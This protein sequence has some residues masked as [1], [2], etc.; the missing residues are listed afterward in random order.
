MTRTSLI[1]LL[2][3]GLISSVATT[4]AAASD[5]NYVQ[6]EGFYVPAWAKP[7]P[8]N[9]SPNRTLHITFA[10]QPFKRAQLD[11]F[12]ASQ[13][14]P[15]SPNYHHWLTP[16]Q[17]GE[18][19][20]ASDADIAGVVGFAQTHG[21]RITH[22]WPNKLFVSADTT[23]AQAEATFQVKLGTYVLPPAM[24]QT[25]ETTFIAPDHKPMLPAALAAKVY[26]VHGLGGILMLRSAMRAPQPAISPLL[27]PRLMPQSGVNPLGPADISNVYHFDTLHYAG[28]TGQN[29]TID[30]F[31]PTKFNRADV[32]AFAANFNITGY[33][34]TETL[35][36]GGA[37]DFG[38]EGEAD[39]DGEMILGQAPNCTLNYVEGQA[40]SPQGW[41]DMWNQVGA[42]NPMV[43]TCS[44]GMPEN[45]ITGSYY[46]AFVTSA[47][48][49]LAVLT[50]QGIGI[51]VASGDAGSSD[52]DGS[53][54][55]VYPASDP[56]ATGVGGT[57]LTLDAFGEWAGE[58]GWS[59]SGGGV[60][61]LFN[62][63]SWQTGPG[64]PA[65]SFR[66]VPDVA[67]M[68]DPA[69][70]GYLTY[71]VYGWAPLEA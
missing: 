31:S 48:T 15:S 45:T 54:T 49:E 38:G 9:V 29:A 30:I 56:N 6:V 35:V 8:V 69:G 67:L 62:T 71:T 28:F 53:G 59:G 19:F 22:I 61:V 51:F 52:I 2:C 65:S 26:A 32:D 1:K 25:N 70:P 21:L 14:N 66:Q 58:T 47:S 18:K 27:T 37:S 60:S 24:T 4:H 36:D 40:N 17:V 43:V 55:P 23:A 10:M 42:D 33:T 20:G 12:I 63:P 7:A 64:V 11:A 16:Q 41:L 13:R 34:L 46:Q 3:I 5:A 39:L 68:A 57:S 44:W 50:S